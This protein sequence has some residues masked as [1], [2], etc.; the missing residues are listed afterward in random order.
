MDAT[1]LEL[2]AG[3]FDSLAADM[4]WGQ[5]TG[6]HREN[7]ALY[8]RALTE[9]HRVSAAGARFVLLTHEVALVERILHDLAS[10]WRVARVVRIFQGGL[11][12]RIYLLERA[13]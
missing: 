13:G 11:H 4:P 5:L 8:P 9:A 1:E 2:P 12:P 10:L 6:S 7:A 3:S